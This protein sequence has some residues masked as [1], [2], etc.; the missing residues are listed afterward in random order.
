MASTSSQ[1]N[2]Y[3]SK[4]L[5]AKKTEKMV[6]MLND[7]KHGTG[8]FSVFS[9][10][11]YGFYFD[12]T[13]IEHGD[14]LYI[15]IDPYSY[16][17]TI[18]HTNEHNHIQ[19]INIYEDNSINFTIYQKPGE[20]RSSTTLLSDKQ[21]RITDSTL[22]NIINKLYDYYICVV[23]PKYDEIIRDFNSESDSDPDTDIMKKKS[24]RAQKKV[25]KLL[26]DL[27]VENK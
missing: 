10:Y 24:Q 17:I 20:D 9:N 8:M 14:L 16:H 25:K 4:A 15:R 7:I 13:D 21:Y 27:L 5:S 12:Y 22:S 23:F 2:R 1:A 11:R 26:L 6:N 19:Y 3:G 18:Q